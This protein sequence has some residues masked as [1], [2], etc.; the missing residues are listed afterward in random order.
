MYSCSAVANESP[1]TDREIAALADQFQQLRPEVLN[2]L[3]ECPSIEN[4]ELNTEWGIRDK[5]GFAAR[6]FELA[7]KYHDFRSLAALCNKDVVYPLDRNPHA[8]KIAEYIERFRT[9]F[10]DE[11][12]QW[13]IEHGISPESCYHI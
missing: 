2:T 9:A 5:F 1:G 3:S 11:L 7:E 13:Y 12:Y 8:S 10:T 4:E 6:A